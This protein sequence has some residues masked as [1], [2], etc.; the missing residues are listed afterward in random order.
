MPKNPF[1]VL[2]GPSGSGKSTLIEKVIKEGPWPLVRTVSCTT[3]EKRAGEVEG[4]DYFFISRQ[5]FLEKRE[6]GAFVE[7]AEVYGDHYGTLKEQAAKAWEKGQVVI[8][9]LDIQGLKSVKKLYPQAL[10]IGVFVSKGGE[11]EE[12]VNKRRADSSQKRALRLESAEKEAGQIQK[13]CPHHVLND[14]LD[15][16]FLSLKKM[17]E[18]YLSCD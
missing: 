10:A 12:R 14:H 4:R 5:E 15:T 2:C 17:I 18:K 6:A 16:A 13:L 7:W 9:D 3:R 8:K 11:L 1:I